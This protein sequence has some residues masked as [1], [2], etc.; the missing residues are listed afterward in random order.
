MNR[1]ENS[2]MKKIAA[3]WVI[4]PLLLWVQPALATDA[5]VGHSHA[6]GEAG[7]HAGQSAH[8]DH[9]APAMT[10]VPTDHVRWQPDAPLRDGMRRMRAIVDALG[11]HEHAHL[12]AI[13][14]QRLTHEVEAAAA[15]MFARCTLAPEPDAALHGIL[16]RLLGAAHDLSADPE[17][18]A[19][20]AT[21]RAALVD[22]A[23]LFDDPGFVPPAAG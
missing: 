14:V 21:M 19:P 1:Q 15:E 2:G 9:A 3:A 6:G 11:H 5:P 20:V 12:D 10:G 23:R 17:A 4:A 18:A 8:V 7:G 16:A 22:Y 13:Q